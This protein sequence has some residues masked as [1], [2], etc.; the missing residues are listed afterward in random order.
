[1]IGFGGG[2]ALI[3]VMEKELVNQRGGLTEGA[4]VQDTVVAN[5]TPG[6]LPVKLGAL[7]G[8]RVGGVWVSLGSALLIALPGTV[9][10]VGLLSMLAALGPRAI[11]LV[12]YASVGIMAFIL[13][14]LA[15]YVLKVI[16]SGGRR[17]PV[18]VSIAGT[19]YLLSGAEKTR[20]LA[21]DVT[22]ASIGG[23]LPE[24]SALGL[25]MVALACIGAY[26]LFE[27]VRHR[28][29]PPQA[30]DDDSL[31]VGARHILK[32][33]ASFTGV[34]LLAVGSVLLVDLPGSGAFLGLVLLSTASSFG[35]GEA[36]VGVADGFFVSSGM[37]EAS[38]FYGQIVPVAN[39]LPGPILIKI[40]AGVSYA[41]GE[42]SG[43]VLLGIVLALLALLVSVGACCALALALLA[44]YNKARHSTFVRNIATFILPVICGLLASTS[45]A[46][47]HS[48]VRIAEAAG[49][50][51]WT[52]LLGSLILAVGSWGARHLLNAPDVAL[53]AA[54]GTLTL[55]TLS[56]L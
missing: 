10:T 25:I 11:E 27:A 17:W 41:F 37:V 51:A 49:T 13:Y 21:E 5:I 23:P 32:G 18:Y 35:G 50:S 20:L 15:H 30:K 2:S 47:L 28:K 46:M 42:T 38:D 36:Y 22:G 29:R 4:F 54:S 16:R 24:L 52:A 9:A 26:S 7:S 19:A 53:I 48:D 14:L 40:A 1:M 12:E 3:P 44:G 39:A 45:A 55:A 8:I 34:T 6:A 56:T 43:S 31:T 33:A